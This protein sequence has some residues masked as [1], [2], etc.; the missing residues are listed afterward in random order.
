MLTALAAAV[1][2][3]GNLAQDVSRILLDISPTSL[4][5]A[6]TT[7]NDETEGSSLHERSLG[8]YDDPSD[9]DAA[10]LMAEEDWGIQE[11]EAEAPDNSDPPMNSDV[12][13]ASPTLPVMDVGST[14]T[15]SP[16][17]EAELDGVA[18]PSDTSAHSLFARAANLPVIPPPLPPAEVY[19]SSHKLWYIR[20]ILL[21][22][23]F[24]HTHHHVT[25]RACNLTL[26]TIRSIFVTLKLIEPTDSMPS[27]L[28][29]TLRRLDL[30]DHFH[31][32]VECSECRRLYRPELAN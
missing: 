6:T 21:L 10:Q 3:W 7:D 8:L 26:S 32:L 23:V 22:V 13:P 20:S 5:V 14:N 19:A 25:F 29:T 30:I 27:T 18:H 17:R 31:I 2:P 11:V 9:L 24:L 16:P 28:T 1:D 15:A 4:E 12:F